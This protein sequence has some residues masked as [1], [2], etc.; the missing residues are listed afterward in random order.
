MRSFSTSSISMTLSLD[1]LT[2]RECHSHR[3]PSSTFKCNDVT[4][5]Q[6]NVLRHNRCCKCKCPPSRPRWCL[7]AALS[8]DQTNFMKLTDAVKQQW[9]SPS[10]C[11]SWCCQA[12]CSCGQYRRHGNRNWVD[13]RCW[14]ALNWLKFYLNWMNWLQVISKLSRPHEVSVPTVT[15]RVAMT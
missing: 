5:Q 10:S 11:W 13:L 1:A 8:P 15:N 3:S 6:S 2:S 4:W 7:A 9:N 14:V 12:N